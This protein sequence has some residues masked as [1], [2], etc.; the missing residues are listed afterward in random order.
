[1]GAP[2]VER[3]INSS[4]SNSSNNELFESPGRPAIRMVAALRSL[5]LLAIH[6]TERPLT[7]GTGDLEKDISRTHH[8]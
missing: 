4:V 3:V 6:P 1:M 5:L 2:A 7:E 8:A